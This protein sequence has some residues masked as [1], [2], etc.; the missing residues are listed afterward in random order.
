MIVASSYFLLFVL[1]RDVPFGDI[2]QATLRNVV[3]L[4]LVAA[5]VRPWV[6]RALKLTPALQSATHAG[7]SI[8]F[9]LAWLWVLT[10][11]GA[12]L[13]AES[14]MRFVVNPFLVGPAASWQLFQGLF[15]YGLLASL[16]ALEQRPARG[17]VIVLTAEEA[18]GEARFLV[19]EGEDIRPLAVAR[20]VSVRGADDYS[21]LVTLDGN[22]L[23]QT[24]LSEFERRLDPA[25]FVRVHR[26]AI[27]NLD[28]MLRAEPAGGGRLLIHLEAGPP[29]HAS[30]AGARALKERT[31]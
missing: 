23:V 21:E 3:S 14:V 4:A 20:L 2:L 19:R 13:G 18:E 10:V 29:V 24:R 30:R 26:S 5:L 27:I 28:R 22:R 1:T 31:L 15:V 11:A 25:R 9:T 12:L 17:G 8:A 6:R 16:I 7:L